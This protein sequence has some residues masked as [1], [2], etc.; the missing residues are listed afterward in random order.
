MPLPCKTQGALHG[1]SPHT[2]SF[3]SASGQEGALLSAITIFCLFSI[4]PS[5]VA[6]Q[7]STDLG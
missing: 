2:K 6:L 5:H 3:F 4:P 1:V 7:S